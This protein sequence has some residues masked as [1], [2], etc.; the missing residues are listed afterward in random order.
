[1]MNKCCKFQSNICNGF[2]KKWN[3]YKKLN[4]NS[5]SKKGH[6]SSKNLVCVLLSVDGGNDGE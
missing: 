3:W 4:Q 5:K 1:M 6:N 2:G